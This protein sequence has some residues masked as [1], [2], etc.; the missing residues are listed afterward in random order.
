MGSVV[1]GQ[2]IMSAIIEHFGLL[3]SEKRPLR[4]E[5]IVAIILM[6]IA[7]TLIY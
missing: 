7:L 1:V 5:K 2:M 3:G 6:I 4:I